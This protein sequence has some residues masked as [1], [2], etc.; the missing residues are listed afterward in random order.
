MNRRSG[1]NWRDPLVALGAAYAWCADDAI[2]DG[3]VTTTLAPYIGPVSLAAVGTGQAIKA[4]SANLGGRFAVAC[5]GTGSYSGVL[6]AV[7][8]AMTI[9]SVVYL[10]AANE[11]LFATTAAG[12]INTGTSQL[13]A[14]TVL[15]VRKL[16]ADI[17]GIAIGSPLAVIQVSALNAAGGTNY[18]NSRTGST[19]AAAG[20]LAGTTVH[21]GGL[22]SANTFALVGAWART[23]IFTRA[24]SASEVALLLTGYGANYRIAIAP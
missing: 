8:A 19:T 1:R 5:S 3:S 12:A 2:D 6:P 10:T 16:A 15:R 22:D 23:G 17:G 9:V 13:L 21:V 4:M 24:L 11:G 14:G 7:P 20:A 18:V